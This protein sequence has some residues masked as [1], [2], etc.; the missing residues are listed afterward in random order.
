MNAFGLLSSETVFQETRTLDE[1][2]P[3]IPFEQKRAIVEII[4]T[5]IEIDANDITI[6]LAYAP[7]SIRNDGK[8]QYYHDDARRPRWPRQHKIVIPKKVL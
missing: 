6:T 7:P 8:R 3:T 5:S 4:T 2:W 1:Q